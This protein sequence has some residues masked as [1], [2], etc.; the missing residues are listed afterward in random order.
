MRIRDP[1]ADTFLRFRAKMSCANVRFVSVSR[2]IRELRS[3]CPIDPA[4]HF[5]LSVAVG[6]NEI[7]SFCSNSPFLTT[8]L[9]LLPD[10][11]FEFIS[12]D[13]FVTF[14]LVGAQPALA[15]FKVTH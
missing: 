9:G 5:N 13:M 3:I 14:K 2:R 7:G 1:P 4:G 11:P 8:S 15:S 6:G 10:C 12:M